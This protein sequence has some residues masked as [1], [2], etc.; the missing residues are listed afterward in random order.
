MRN[1]VKLNNKEYQFFVNGVAY[2]VANFEQ[3]KKLL[4]A[5][6]TSSEETTE[7]TNSNEDVSPEE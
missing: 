4:A 5:E 3:V 6:E 7:A 1:R 2:N